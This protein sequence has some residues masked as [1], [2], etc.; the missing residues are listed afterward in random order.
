MVPV[1]K[2]TLRVPSPSMA[3]IWPDL[4]SLGW[5]WTSTAVET[6]TDIVAVEERRGL[7]RRVDATR[8]C[9]ACGG[10]GSAVCD[11]RAVSAFSRDDWRAS[12]RNGAAGVFITDL[13]LIHI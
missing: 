5:P 12:P 2:A 8:S 13:S 9:E 6:G 1:M 3:F 7:F 11:A 4:Y 10:G